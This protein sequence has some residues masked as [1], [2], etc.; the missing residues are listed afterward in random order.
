MTTKA[1]FTEEEWEL[2]LA[3]PPQAGMI[4][5]MADRGGSIRESFSMSKAYAEARQHHGQSELIDEIV[6][7]KP[8][9]D[10]TRQPNYEELK[11][12]SLGRLRE[13]VAVLE[14]KATPEE[15][16]GYRQFVLAVARRVA[17]AHKEDGV[18]VSDAEAAVVA[19]IT[20]TLGTSGAET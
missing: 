20:E 12:Y 18:A 10:R 16:E 3:G 8:K 14:Q 5:V 17:E 19:E 15:V 1:D 4:V 7:A 11:A 9:V 2:V 6:S 13:A